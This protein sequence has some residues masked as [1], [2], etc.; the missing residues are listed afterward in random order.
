MNDAPNSSLVERFY[1]WEETTPNTVFLRQPKRQNWTEL[2]YAEAGLETR[3]IVTALKSSGLKPGDHI[4][5]YSKNCYHWILAD[6][7]IM[8]GGFVSVPFYASLPGEQLAEVIHLA[9]L[10]AL[11]VG[12][13]DE[14]NNDHIEA[15]P[16][17]LVTIKFPHYE[18]NSSV[19]L[20]LDWDDLTQISEPDTD[21]FIPDPDDLWT[22]KFTSGTTGTPKGV[23]HVHRTPAAIMTA[24]QETD[25]IGVF[26]IENPRFFS[27]LPLNH[28]GERIG[29][30]LPAI[31][32]GGSISFV[33]SLETFASNIQQTQPTTFFGVPRIW[34]NMYLAVLSKIPEKTPEFSAGNT[35]CF[36]PA[37][38]K[39]QEGHGIF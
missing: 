6:L 33:E 11:F 12:K 4:G 25:W 37:Q 21:N 26:H 14:W 31:W 16:D 20:G 24:E 22:I 3:R 17:N 18:G 28:V 39:A 10:K 34:T 27:Y 5:I 23:M 8:I 9:N 1:H 35:H 2:T 7:A 38:E 19:N 29:V 32:L 15:V 13:L 36:L 30:E